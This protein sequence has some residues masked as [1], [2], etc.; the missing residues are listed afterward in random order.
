MVEHYLLQEV[1]K[2]GSMVQVKAENFK[3]EVKQET[4]RFDR[5]GKEKKRKRVKREWGE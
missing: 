3:G 2:R 5:R 1:G 4:H